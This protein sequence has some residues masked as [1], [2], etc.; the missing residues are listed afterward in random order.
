M[1]RMVKIALLTIV[2]LIGLASTLWPFVLLWENRC[3]GRP[4]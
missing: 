2:A 1:P 4:D 3:K